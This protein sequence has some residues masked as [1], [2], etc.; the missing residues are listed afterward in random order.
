M[1]GAA[2]LAATAIGAVTAAPA[3]STG[4]A[5]NEATP[6]IGAPQSQVL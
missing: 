1:R 6:A 2:V 3:S 5:A 4:A